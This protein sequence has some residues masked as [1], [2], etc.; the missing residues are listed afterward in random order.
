MRARPFPARR[1]AGAKA[2][3][4]PPCGEHAVAPLWPAWHTISKAQGHAPHAHGSRIQI[5]FGQ[6]RSPGREREAEKRS[7]LRDSSQPLRKQPSFTTSSTSSNHFR[8]YFTRY[9]VR[10]TQLM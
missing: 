6:G 3:S 2:Y 8:I 1:E 10:Y 9:A 5:R 4:A 7:E